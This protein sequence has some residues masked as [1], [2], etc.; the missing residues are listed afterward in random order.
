MTIWNQ[1]GSEKWKHV[2]KIIILKH[3][4]WPLGG[5]KSFFDSSGFL[6][7]SSLVG[8]MKFLKSQGVY[9]GSTFGTSTA[10]YVLVHI[11]L[12]FDIQVI[13]PFV[14]LHLKN[15]RY[16]TI[17]EVSVVSNIH[18]VEPGFRGRFKDWR[19][20][21]YHKS[22]IKDVSNK[23]LAC[24]TVLLESPSRSQQYAGAVVTLFVGAVISI[25]LA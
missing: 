24:F 19:S 23:R 13:L 18:L 6:L 1:S 4:F 9:Q 10:K 3:N 14:Y 2:E 11:T 7:R 20:R 17:N 16:F 15:W 22:A 25:L 5:V 8:N 12:I 21:V